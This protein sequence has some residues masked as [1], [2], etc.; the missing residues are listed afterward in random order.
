MPLYIYSSTGSFVVLILPVVIVSD[1]CSRDDATF[2]LETRPLCKKRRAT[3]DSMPVGRPAKTFGVRLS[4]KLEHTYGSGRASDE[5]GETCLGWKHL[6]QTWRSK[7][8]R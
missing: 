4:L 7:S 1:L 3:E 6:A 8:V 5:E 2:D